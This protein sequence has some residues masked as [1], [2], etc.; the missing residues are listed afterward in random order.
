LARSCSFGF[1]G[2]A[3]VLAKTKCTICAAGFFNEAQRFG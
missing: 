3:C 2:L 1:L